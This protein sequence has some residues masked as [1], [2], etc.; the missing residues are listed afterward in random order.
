MN[1]DHNKQNKL[2]SKLKNINHSINKMVD[3]VRTLEK[4]R[5]LNYISAV[6]ETELEKVLQ[7][8]QEIEESI[9]K[10]NLSKEKPAEQKTVLRAIGKDRKLWVSK[11]SLKETREDHS[12]PRKQ[13]YTSNPIDPASMQSPASPAKDINNEVNNMVPRRPL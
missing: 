13:G 4:M 10:I 2:Y 3:C 6:D 7:Q 8:M 12:V 5:S 9:E 11:P 1:N